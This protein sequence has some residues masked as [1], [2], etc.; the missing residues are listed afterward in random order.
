MF[1]WPGMG[2]LSIESVFE[3]DYTVLMG[4]TIIISSAV[5]FANLLADV[6]YAIVDPRIRYS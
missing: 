5:L 2:L 4:L 3:R 1:S 6:L